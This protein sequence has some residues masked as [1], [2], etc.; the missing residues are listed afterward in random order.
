M[1]ALRH[2]CVASIRG[3]HVG[4]ETQFILFSTHGYVK[5][6]DPLVKTRMDGQ[7]NGGHIGGKNGLF[8]LSSCLCTCAF[9]GTRKRTWHAQPL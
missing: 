5:V 4:V 2:V 3:F 8:Q 7:I 1:H 9:I 6:E